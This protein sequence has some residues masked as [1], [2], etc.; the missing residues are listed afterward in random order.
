MPKVVIAEDEAIIRLDLSEILKEAG[1]EVVGA[2]CRGDEALQLVQDLLPDIAILDIK[3]PGMDGLA[4]AR[5][6]SEERLCAVL[7]LTAF[8]QRNLIEEARNSG[9]LGYLVKPFQKSDLIPAIEVALGRFAEREALENEVAE[10]RDDKEAVSAK[11]ETRKLLDRAKGMLMDEASLKEVEAFRFIQKWAM[12][13]RTTMK[14]TATKI[15]S[16][17]LKP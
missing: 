11:L 8:S 3:M 13:N 5:A 15:L 1:Y 16:G 6:I 10:L 17:E 2:A 12:D 7:I 14:D 9:A 4:V